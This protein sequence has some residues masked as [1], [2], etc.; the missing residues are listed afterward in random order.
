MARRA[1]PWGF[2]VVAAAGGLALCA[3]GAARAEA[4]ACTVV[5]SLPA[6]LSLPGRYCLDAD[7]AIAGSAVDAVQVTAS[8]V[9][10]DCNE[11]RLLGTTAANTGVGVRI[12]SAAARVA[13]RHCRIEGFGNGIY[14][15]WVADTAPRQVRVQGNTIVGPTWT[16]IW[17]FGSGNVVEGN[18][19][20]ALRGGA[21]GPYTTGI[22]L[23]S[24]PGYAAGNVVRGN[25]IRAFR[26]TYPTVEEY[27]LS[28]GIQASYQQGLVAED[29]T[30]A[31]LL[32][33]T[34][35]GVY[36]IATDHSVNTLVRGNVIVSAPVPQAAPLDGGNWAG[37]FLQGTV[38]EQATNQCADNTVGHFNGD[39]V[40]C[41]SAADTQF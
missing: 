30:V 35:G 14:T 24:G 31:G 25:E 8:D 10:L 37:I 1:P 26:P 18:R 7:L 22:Y 38:E 19:I 33:R 36:G 12:A 40:G 5:D 20:S 27:N 16:G 15:D 39:I 11:H 13:V 32:A 23:A 9:V 29:N 34:G 4:T 2:A 41:G 21:S 17:L 6:V 28:M 3:P